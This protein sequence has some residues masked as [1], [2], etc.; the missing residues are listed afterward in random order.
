MDG[1]G[2]GLRALGAGSGR[3][4]RLGGGHG[5]GG[6]TRRRRLG[7]ASGSL[8]VLG[9]LHA[10]RHL[11]GVRSVRGLGR[12]ARRHP[13]HR[14]RDTGNDACALGPR[15]GLGHLPTVRHLA[16]V[17]G[18]RDNGSLRPGLPGRHLTRIR[19]NP[20]DGALGQG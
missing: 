18:D 2:L 7:S 11:R 12:A 6:A 10:L 15:S 5:V 17:R 1:R 8:A 3:V 19:D 9:H 13:G 4:R 20:C 16:R 14:N